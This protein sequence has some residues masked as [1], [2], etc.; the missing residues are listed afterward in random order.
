MAHAPGARLAPDGT[1]LVHATRY[2]HHDERTAAD[3]LAADLHALARR[4]GIT[5]DDVV[6]ERYLHRMVVVSASV[7]P[8]GGGLGGAP[9]STTP[10][11]TACSS[12]ATG[13]APRAGSPTP[14]W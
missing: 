3:E 9:T 10:G 8:A 5:E 14:R 1:A 4:T 7:T 13:S 12:P 6:L 2:L 11:S